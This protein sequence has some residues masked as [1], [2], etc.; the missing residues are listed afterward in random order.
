MPF[1]LVSSLQQYICWSLTLLSKVILTGEP[2]WV[3]FRQVSI[4]VLTFLV[5]TVS[6]TDLDPSITKKTKSDKLV[7][8]VRMYTRQIV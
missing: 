7:I 2:T 3:Q 1:W 5:V 4:S 6:S 8:K